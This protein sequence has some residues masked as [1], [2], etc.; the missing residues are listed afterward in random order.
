LSN[1]ARER[2]LGLSVMA[3]FRWFCEFLILKP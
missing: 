2:S 1:Q 3:A